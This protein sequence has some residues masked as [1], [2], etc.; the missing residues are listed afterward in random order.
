MCLPIDEGKNEGPRLACT[1]ASSTCAKKEK[2]NELLGPHSNP[3]S[4]PPSVQ[5]F[6]TKNIP[7]PINLNEY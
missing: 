6:Y 1:G 7:G 5:G 2:K 3:V 4:L